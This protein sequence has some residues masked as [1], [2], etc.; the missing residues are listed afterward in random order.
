AYRL[1]A[2]SVG[3]AVLFASFVLA[4]VARGASGPPALGRRP[5]HT[6]ALV[7]ASLAG[8]AHVAASR[9][10]AATTGALAFALL[11]HATRGRSAVR[12][13]LGALA[14]AVAMV[15]WGSELHLARPSEIAA[16]AGLSAIVLAAAAAACHA[17]GSVEAATPVAVV[18]GFL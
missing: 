15:S 9:S 11:G 3:A 8:V 5:A 2:P 10:L 12:G 17:L 6:S 14:A 16:W 18:A 4:F 1:G 7:A 13:S